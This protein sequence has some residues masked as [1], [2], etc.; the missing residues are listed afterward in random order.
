MF[1]CV[2]NSIKFNKNLSF[3]IANFSKYISKSRTKHLP[4]N[5]KRAGKGY[6]KG[7]RARKEGRLTSLGKFTV[8]SS[9]RTNLIVPDLTGFK[10]YYY[11]NFLSFFSFLLFF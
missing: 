8:I 2:F 4:L 3:Q 5:T 11:F 10:V 6:Y 1:G 7:Y 9:M